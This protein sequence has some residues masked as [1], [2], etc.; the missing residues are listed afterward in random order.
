MNTGFSSTLL[1]RIALLKD[2]EVRARIT[3]A[4]PSDIPA[5]G[6]VA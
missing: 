1:L 2:P 4:A 5:A 6:P 3:Q